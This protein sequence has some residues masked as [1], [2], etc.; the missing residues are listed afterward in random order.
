MCPRE[1]LTRQ[2][3]FMTMEDFCVIL[4]KIGP[5]AGS[6]HLHGYGEP[7]LDRHLIEKV[8]RLKKNCPDCRSF[9]ITTLGVK[10]QESFFTDLAQ[11]GLDDMVISL[12]GFTPESYQKIHG[13]DQLS[14]VKSNLERLARAMKD[15]PL[16]ASIKIPTFSNLNV[17]NDMSERDAFC[18][19]ALGLGF[20]IGECPYVHNY[21]DGRS[22]NPPKHETLCPVI[23]GIRRHVLNITWDLD[24]IPC[25]Y[26]FNAQI[27][28]GNLRCQ[29]LDDIFSSRDYMNFYIAHQTG[30][31]SAYPVCENCEK[32]DCL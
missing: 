4:D 10:V 18:R 1:R 31:L 25:C 29:S 32:I 20:E 23:H 17:P 13:V 26:D 3:G 24:V 8:R 21:G 22:Y 14:R 2:I 30:S 11:A 7:L 6:I 19:W 16:K 9:I 15:A 28:F 27:R 5:Y 12:Y